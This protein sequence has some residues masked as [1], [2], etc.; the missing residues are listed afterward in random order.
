ML[1]EALNTHKIYPGPLHV[2]KGVD[3]TIAAA[4]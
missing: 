3:L 1:V 4:K 2:L